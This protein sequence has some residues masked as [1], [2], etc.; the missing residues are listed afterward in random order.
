MARER[1]WLSENKRFGL[2]VQHIRLGGVKT[3]LEFCRKSLL[4][5]LSGEM[6]S[7][8]ELEEEILPWAKKETATSWNSAQ[9]AMTVGSIW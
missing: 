7:I 1:K 2:D 8:P 9:K 3:R 4:S 5:Y 6:A